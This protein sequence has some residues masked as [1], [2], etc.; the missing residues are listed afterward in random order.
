MNISTPKKPHDIA[1]SNNQRTQTRQ[2]YTTHKPTPH[3]QTKAL[4]PLLQIFHIEGSLPGSALLRGKLTSDSRQI[5]LKLSLD[6]IQCG[7][8]HLL[9]KLL[10]FLFLFKNLRRLMRD[11]QVPGRGTCSHSHENMKLS[12]NRH[13]RSYMFFWLPTRPKCTNAVQVTWRDRLLRLELQF[14][15]HAAKHENADQPLA[16]SRKLRTWQGTFKET[17]KMEKHGAMLM[18]Q[19]YLFVGEAPLHLVRHAIPVTTIPLQEQLHLYCKSV[20]HNNTY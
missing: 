19:R 10:C 7:S 6:L 8:G 12:W 3:W 11:D 5:S 14:R 13:I 20:T 16:C 9:G 17:E 4:L 18:K 2:H 1:A 15:V